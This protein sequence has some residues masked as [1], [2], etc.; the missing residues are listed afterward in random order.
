[1][2]TLHSLYGISLKSQWHLPF[3]PSNDGELAQVTLQEFPRPF[4]ARAFRQASN[5]SG[6]DRWF[7]CFSLADGSTYLRWSGL[8]EF[9]V[10]PDGR[11]IFGRR[12]TRGTLAAFH[13]Y[14]L[15]QV[16]STALLKQGIESLHST[17]VVVGGQGVAFL[18]D[19]G[20]GKSSLGAV[21]VRAGFS[22]LTDDLLVVARRGPALYA[23][24]GA[25]R[26]KLFPRVARCILN[27][28]VHGVAMNNITAKLVIP[29]EKHQVHQSAVPL[30][31][32]YVLRPP[33]VRKASKKISI[34]PLSQRRAFLELVKNTFNDLNL[35]SDRLRRQFGLA[36]TIASEIGVKSLSYP[37][38]LSSLPS[39][40]EA[41]LADLRR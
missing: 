9:L 28:G 15:N 39:V 29:L 41:I 1:M 27:N 38:A 26:I 8:F 5:L 30:K 6:H 19:C 13:T 7:R 18:G 25:P 17:C 20:Y 33:S 23:F 11:D 36:T 31:A 24:P 14:L 3:P 22:L 32:I 10:S 37:R 2:Q 21:F 12:L 40:R 35:E 34:R 4:S 16:L